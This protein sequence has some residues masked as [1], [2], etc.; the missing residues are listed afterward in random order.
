MFSYGSFQF[1]VNIRSTV[2]LCEEEM[3]GDEN[4][5]N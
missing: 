2:E 4:L 1:E 5:G 3:L